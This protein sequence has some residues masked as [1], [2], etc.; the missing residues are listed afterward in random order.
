MYS[1]YNCRENIGGKLNPKEQRCRAAS[2]RN[3][4]P[5]KLTQCWGKRGWKRP[6]QHEVDLQRLGGIPPILGLLVRLRFSE[7]CIVRSRSGK[8]QLVTLHTGHRQMERL[9]LEGH[10]WPSCLCNSCFCQQ[11]RGSNP[12]Y[13]FLCSPTQNKQVCESP[14]VGERGGGVTLA[15]KRKCQK[16]TESMLEMHR[17]WENNPYAEY[18]ESVCLERFKMLHPHK[19]NKTLFLKEK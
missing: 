8:G 15:P 6:K 10:L 17:P 9:E 19:R 14:R 2:Y 4:E 5:Q 3:C 11:S 1:K 16:P 13:N 12:L 18:F 7:E